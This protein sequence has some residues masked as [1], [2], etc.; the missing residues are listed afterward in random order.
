MA[1]V[2]GQSFWCEVSESKRSSQALSA[3]KSNG[4]TLFSTMGHQFDIEDSTSDAS[5]FWFLVLIAF[6]WG[7]KKNCEL[8]LQNIIHYS[9]FIS[10]RNA[11]RCLRGSDEEQYMSKPAA[12]AYDS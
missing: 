11:F 3:A 10:H 6:Q 1:L 2:V 4:A 7:L 9:L 8:T 5:S 12:A